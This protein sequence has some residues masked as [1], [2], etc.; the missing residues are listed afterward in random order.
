MAITVF[1]VS[2]VYAAKSGK[3]GENLTW[4]LD[5]EGT[6]TISGTG[7]MDNY[8]DTKPA[9][10]KIYLDKIEHIVL[11]DGVTSVGNYAFHPGLLN[12]VKLTC[13][14][15]LKKIGDYAF[16][17]GYREFPWGLDEESP[18]YIISIEYNA[19]S[20]NWKEISFG[21]G[22]TAFNSRESG[23]SLLGYRKTSIYFNKVAEPISGYF[24]DDNSQKY[25]NIEWTLDK[26]GT[27]TVTGN[28]NMPEN[29]EYCG[30]VIKDDYKYDYSRAVKKIIIGEGISE[31][32]N[33]SYFNNLSEISLPQSLKKVDRRTFFCDRNLK[34]L[35]L[36]K[37]LE[38]IGMFAFE[39][40]GLETVYI[41]KSI[42]EINAFA[43]VD[44]ELKN[45]YYEGSEDDWS[46]IES[47]QATGLIDDGVKIYYNYLISKEGKCGENLTWTLDDD[48]TLTISGTGA[49]QEISE[50]NKIWEDYK[51]EITSVIIED[52][53]TNIAANAFLHC[54]NLKSVNIPNTVIEIGYSSF[55]GTGIEKIEI[56]SSV[57]KINSLAFSNCPLTEV[58]LNE[59]LIEIG[60][61]IFK[62]S[63]NLTE[64][65]LPDS[66]EALDGT[67]AYSYIKNIFIPQ[68]AKFISD[69]VLDFTYG[70][71][72]VTVDEK[73]P[74]YSSYDGVLYN[75][76][77]TTLISCPWQKKGT[78]RIA[79]GTLII[80]DIQNIKVDKII[81]PK[82]VTSINNCLNFSDG[83]SESLLTDIYYEGSENDWNNI[84]VNHGEFCEGNHLLIPENV[85]LHCLNSPSVTVAINA[86]NGAVTGDGIYAKEDSVTVTATPDNGYVFTGWYA[87][88]TLLSTES[89]YTF[90]VDKDTA[91]TAKFE[92][93]RSSH[94]GSRGGSSS[95]SCII[96]LVTNGGSEL[97]SISVTKGQTI[98]IIT[99][100]TKKGYV[101]TGW[102]SDKELTKPYNKDEK[103]TDSTTLYAG[104]KTD[105]A[106]QLILTIGKKAATVFGQTKSNDVAPKIVNDRTM[107]PARFVAESLG[108]VVTWSDGKQEVT[109][110][111]KNAKNEDI[112]ILIYI[113]SDIAY[114]NGKEIKLDSPAFIE[115]DRTY[116]PIRFISEQLGANV[117]WNENEQSVTIT[118]P[119]PAE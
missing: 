60:S 39:Q 57:K 94:K 17:M 38:S 79:D 91:L 32:R 16:V 44:A 11:D 1:T 104:W 12:N 80:D 37:N 31:I 112:T 70:A 4:T 84:T 76:D 33:L 53:A 23:D 74:Y 27:F 69:G 21:V 106:R 119:E 65:R 99:E 72:S 64:I 42:K 97:K 89:T 18:L 110:K 86:E 36:P 8:T 45:V 63:S 83:L 117:E 113:G 88:N 92:I 55:L 2:P 47:G 50:E 19:T 51:D 3:C 6:L 7:N 78:L 49:M 41:P 25:S 35:V 48:G 114:V 28:G 118:V 5:D 75:K 96:K 9:P 68:K 40:S 105:P 61:H 15:T 81:V 56:P 93:I 77:K 101:F 95:S 20:K 43:F 24:W 29:D 103:I 90:T 71:E 98:G 100:P 58:K 73:N 66:V 115:N 52:G 108:A 54:S 111:G 107:L 62:L 10:W 87:D 13:G 102:Y 34:K 116:T 67:F 82:S 22:N 26:N 59:G 109:I 85:K 30:L 14:E 46:K